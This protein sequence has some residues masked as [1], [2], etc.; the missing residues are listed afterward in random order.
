MIGVLGLLRFEPSSIYMF[1]KD[2][3]LLFI[4][5]VISEV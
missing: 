2:P 5:Y 4:Y 3:N 1:T